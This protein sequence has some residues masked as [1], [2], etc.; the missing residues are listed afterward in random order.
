MVPSKQADVVGTFGTKGRP[1]RV[2][3]SK[4]ETRLRVDWKKQ[5]S[6]WPI[7]F[8]YQRL[9]LYIIQY[10]IYPLYPTAAARAP[11]RATCTRHGQ[12]EV[13]DARDVATHRV[14]RR[15]SRPPPIMDICRQPDTQLMGND[16][17][18]SLHKG[19]PARRSAVD[20]V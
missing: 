6:W 5:R 18:L 12:M 9:P 10:W 16:H 17:I 15:P 11:L 3:K 14:H 19:R 7:E 8:R 1:Y 20:I 4:S 2:L 13:A